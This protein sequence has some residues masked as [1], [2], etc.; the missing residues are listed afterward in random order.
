MK[1]DPPKPDADKKPASR[2]YDGFLEPLPVPDMS[3][4]DTE[5]A[6]GR[7]EDSFSSTAEAPKADTEEAEPAPPNFE[8]TQPMGAL[9]LPPLPPLKRP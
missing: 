5:T 8:D 6:W 2:I 9:D 4:S 1:S 7:W 3:E